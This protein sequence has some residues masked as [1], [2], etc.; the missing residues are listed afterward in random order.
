MRQKLHLQ[1]TFIQ[2]QK[3]MTNTTQLSSN[4]TIA[5]NNLCLCTMRGWMDD[6]NGD[7][8]LRG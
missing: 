2:E 5:L 8:V 1:T 4:H 3:T 7:E 6:G